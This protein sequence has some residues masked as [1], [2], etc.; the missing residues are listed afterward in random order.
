MDFCHQCYG[1][2]ALRAGTCDVSLKCSMTNLRRRAQAEPK[3]FPG[4]RELYTDW[5]RSVVLVVS[6]T[7][8]PV[9]SN[10]TPVRFRQIIHLTNLFQGHPTLHR[11]LGLWLIF[12]CNFVRPISYISVYNF[13]DDEKIFCQLHCL[14]Q[15]DFVY[16]NNKY[17]TLVIFY[18]KLKVKIFK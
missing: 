9:E 2:V 14:T 15:Y 18:V 6:I 3:T 12:F 11:S 8:E 16:N 4:A 7:Q 5:L 13:N 10:N 17:T 1:N